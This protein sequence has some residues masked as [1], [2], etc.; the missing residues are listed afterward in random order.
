MGAGEQPIV[1]SLSQSM[2]NNFDFKW[3]QASSQ[4]SLARANQW[5]TNVGLP[6]DPLPI[7]VTK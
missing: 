6:Y 5:A 7:R 2:G 1:L 4:L 3:E